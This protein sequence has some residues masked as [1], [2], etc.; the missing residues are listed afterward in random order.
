MSASPKEGPGAKSTGKKGAK[1]LAK[2][3]RGNKRYVAN[4]IYVP[5]RLATVH[6][7]HPKTVV[8]G[9]SDSRM[10]SSVVLDDPRLGSIFEVKTAGQSLGATDLES[11]DYAVNHLTPRPR[12][13]LVL[14][15]THC[16]A[17]KTCYEA[18][19]NPKAA[20]LKTEFPAVIAKIRPA[21]EAVLHRETKECSGSATKRL[22]LEATVLHARMVAA[23]LYGRYKRT[24]SV[25]AALYDVT[26]GKLHVLELLVPVRGRASAQR[27]AL[28]Q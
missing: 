2:L 21:V 22:L 8:V 26:S 5:Q 18:L 16:G 24:M 15:H 6:A 1:Q 25:A 14:G 19:T 27:A 7:Q 12:L 10:P 9:C 17:V 3:V 11:I 13:I 23:K 20:E 4:P 28:D